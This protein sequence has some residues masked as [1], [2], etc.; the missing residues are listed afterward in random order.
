MITKTIDTTKSLTFSTRPHEYLNSCI[1]YKDGYISS[2][3]NGYIPPEARKKARLKR[4]K[5]K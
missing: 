1:Y 4:K 2:Y 5:K 3:K